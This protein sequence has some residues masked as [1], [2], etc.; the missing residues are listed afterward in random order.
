TGGI[1]RTLAESA[2][3]AALWAVAPASLRSKVRDHVAAIGPDGW[4]AAPFI[5][6]DTPEAR[7]VRTAQQRPLAARLLK[8]F[9]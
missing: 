4:E 9:A 1:M 6:N 3:P 8:D 5:G 7:A 2:D